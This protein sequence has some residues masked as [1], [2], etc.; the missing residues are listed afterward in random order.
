MA[1]L[2]PPLLR[3]LQPPRSSRSSVAPDPVEEAVDPR[4][5]AGLPGLGAARSEGHD[6]NDR[7]LVVDAGHEGASAVVLLGGDARVREGHGH[8]VMKLQ[9]QKVTK[10]KKGK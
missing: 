4:I 1:S 10:E 3:Q 5:N 7:P 9:W 6:A 2:F 8:H